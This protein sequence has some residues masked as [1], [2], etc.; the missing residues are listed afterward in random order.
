[1]DTNSNTRCPCKSN[2][3]NLVTKGLR[4]H[5]HPFS[6]F[7]PFFIISFSYVPSAVDCGP[8]LTS[9]LLKYMVVQLVF[10]PFV[11]NDMERVYVFTENKRISKQ[12]SMEIF[13]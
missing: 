1:M 13:G 5:G 6:R 12:K 7:V 9:Y 10:L 2:S 4:H 3:Y 11:K 8:F